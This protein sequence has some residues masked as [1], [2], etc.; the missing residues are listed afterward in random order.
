MPFVEPIS[1]FVFAAL[2]AVAL[3]AVVQRLAP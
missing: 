3:E 1:L 2:L